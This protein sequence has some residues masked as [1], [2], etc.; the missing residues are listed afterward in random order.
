ML[1]S[2]LPRALVQWLLVA[3]PQTPPLCL[4]PTAWLQREEVEEVAGLDE[5]AELPL[6]ELLARYGNYHLHASAAGEASE[7]GGV[8]D[9]EMAGGLLLCAVLPVCCAACVPACPAQGTQAGQLLRP[10]CLPRCWL[11]S[12]LA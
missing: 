2:P 12:P 1:G 10:A 3:Q 5:E 8:E 4:C 6:E 9:E 11:G 7:D